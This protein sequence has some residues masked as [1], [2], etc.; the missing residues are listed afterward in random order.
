MKLDLMKNIAG[1]PTWGWGLIIL[2]GGVG[3]YFI[4]Q[5]NA[6]A[7]TNAANVPATSTTPAYPTGTSVDSN[8]NVVDAN[9]NILSGLPSP[10]PT[11]PQGQLPILPPGMCPN[12]DASG[13]VISFSP[14]APTPTPTQQPTTKTAVVRARDITPTSRTRAYDLNHPGGV[15]LR[16][17]PGGKTIGLAPFGT[18]IQI[19]ATPVV[20]A[21]NFKTG[22]ASLSWF[23][24]S[25]GSYIS[26]YDLQGGTF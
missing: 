16:D 6:Q 8:G 5:H 3:A 20:G 13:N 1:I 14:C 18:P 12:Y 23:K 11:I 26:A 4:T 22:G 17:S 19:S 10:Y 2:I 21:P 7:P 9:G 25:T 24:T 15:P